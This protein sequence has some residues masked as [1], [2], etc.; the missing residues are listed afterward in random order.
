R[1]FA[2]STDASGDV[3]RSGTTS[4]AAPRNGRLDPLTMSIAS[5]LPIKPSTFT[6]SGPRKR[7]DSASANAFLASPTGSWSQLSA[8][9]AGGDVGS[10]RM[11]LARGLGSL[12]DT[13]AR[14]GTESGQRSSKDDWQFDRA[15]SD[16]SASTTLLIQNALA[17]IGTSPWSYAT[18]A[19]I[20][21]IRL[22]IGDRRGTG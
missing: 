3:A 1:L 7:A 10:S 22:F 14:G 18:L 11:D 2:Q 5:A 8:S 13:G 19:L 21:V 4:G 12:I 16:G 20:F 6:T 17:A 9:G 15:D